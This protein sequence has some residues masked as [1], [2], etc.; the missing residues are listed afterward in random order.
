MIIRKEEQKL[1]KKT[2]VRGGEG[3]LT[4]IHRVPL[5]VMR[6]DKMVAEVIVPPGGSIG[7]HEHKGEVE[8]YIIQS[9]QGFVVDNGVEATVHKGDCIITGNGAAH[10]IKNTGSV[11]LVFEAIIIGY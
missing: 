8:Y 10:S 11:P 7:L 1:E 4:F 6:H 5:E 3:E 2:N 9:G